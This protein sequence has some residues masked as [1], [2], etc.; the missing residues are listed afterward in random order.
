MVGR[1]FFKSLILVATLLSFD[2]G[3]SA[4]ASEL[5][6][7]TGD[8]LTV[9]GKAKVTISDCGDGTPCGE[10]AWLDPVSAEGDIDGNNPDPALR[11]RPLVGVM[12]LWGF[13]EK[14]GRWI[15]GQ[16]Y[17][18][19]DGKTYGSRIE[20]ETHSILKVKGCVGPIC[21]TQIWSRA[22]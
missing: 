2:A 15:K 8:W 22:G 3:L 5:S 6:D 20:L 1:T 21:K 4:H 19:E 12:M 10:I 9:G 7:V 14:K 16:I 11:E 18:P 17:N 13:K